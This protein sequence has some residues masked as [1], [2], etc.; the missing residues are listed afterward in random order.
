MFG[1]AGYT[2]LMAATAC[3]LIRAGKLWDDLRS[4]LILVVTMF[5]AIALCVDETMA[6]DPR[7]GVVGC[8]GGFLFAVAVTETVLRAIRLRLPG[9]YRAAY[10]LILGH[11]FLYPIMLVPLLRDPPSPHLE[12]SLFG[13]AAL[14]GLVLLALVPAARGGAALVAKNGSPWRWPLYPWSLFV[15]MVI[16]LGVRCYSLCVS[17]Y[18][19]GGSQTIFGPYFL[20]PIGLALSV[21]WLEIGIA[22]GRTTVT[23]A[24]ATVPLGLAYLA[25]VGHRDQALY[26]HFLDSFRGTLGGS[27]AFLTLGAWILVLAYAA[28]RRVPQA[29]DLMAVGLAALAVVGPE[30]ITLSDLDPA[31]PLPLAAA[32]LVLGS[33][34]LRRHSTG[35]AVLGAGFLVAGVFRG[36]ADFWPDAVHQFVTIHLL[37]AALLLIG[38]VFEDWLAAMARVGGVSLVLVL[39]VAAAVHSSWPPVALPAVVRLWYPL[40]AIVLAFAY[41]LWIRERLCWASAAANLAAWLAYSG[42]EFYQQLRRG[43]AGLD[44]IACGIV[45]F[46]IAVGISLRKAGLWPASCVRPLETIRKRRPE[47]GQSHF[48]P[49]TPQNR[50]S[51]RLFSDGS[52]V[53][54]VFR[55]WD[56]HAWE[57]SARPRVKQ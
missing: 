32:G 9:W 2:I 33:V 25:L 29:W 22:S 7:R 20:V 43:V 23:V 38:A 40:F 30:T 24:A 5:M 11:V 14:A 41:G 52:L 12:W 8:A 6:E 31:R 18:Y 50:D 55:V 49:R 53:G 1:L 21:V 10:Y 42:A 39:G 45:L 34:A 4:M 51:P 35:R 54:I 16:G 57:A 27:P 37:M 48:A 3:F 15:V 13:F 28:F 26:I 19:V 47:G 44:Q 36:W 17:F 56:R 46:L